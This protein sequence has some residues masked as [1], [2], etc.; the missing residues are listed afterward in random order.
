MLSTGVAL[1]VAATT[2]GTASSATR[3]VGSS[4]AL[5][6]GTLRVVQSAGAFDTLDPQLAYVYNDWQVLH[7]T[8]LLLVDRPD[9]AGQAGGQLQPEGAKSFP[10]ISNKGRT[11]TFHLREGLRFSDGSPVT[12]ASYRRAWERILSP[13]MFAQYGVFDQLNAMVVGAQKFTDD[14]AAHIS[15]IDA[16][17]LTLTFHLTKPNATFIST[18]A[19]PWLGAVKPSMPYTKK[20]T[21]ILEYPSA[22]PYYIAADRPG[23]LVVLKRNRYYHGARPAN[24]DEIVIRSYPSSNGEAALLQIEQNQVDYDMA[25]VPAADVATV[26]QKYGYP[27]NR[28][29]QFHVGTESCVTWEALNY[30]R[31]PTNDPRVRKALNYALGRT[32]ITNLWGPYA[33]TPTDQIL[34][35]GMPGYEKFTLYGNDPNVAKAEQVGG[36]SPK[37]APPLTIGYYAASALST[38]EAELEQSE[39]HQIGLTVNL[40]PIPQYGPFETPFDQYN[41]VQSGYC[42]DYFDGFDLIHLF[43]TKKQPGALSPYAFHDASFARQAA[44]AASLTGRARVRAYAALDRLLMTKYAPVVPLYVR[45][46]RYL[47]SKR[48]HNIVFSHYLG[49]PILNAM[50]VR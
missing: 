21:G 19:I 50:S 36:S 8:Q 37:N 27:E 41:I 35:P 24:P 14:K 11:V 12:A 3:K 15:G 18:L 28:Q 7:S 1:L 39:L 34:V 6:G 26:A 45:N 42:A 5:R 22:G 43:A 23:S 4:E 40:S 2:V 48:V 44:H 31:P 46:F 29:S 16:H 17:G 30:D 47:T 32:Q 49:G 9:K 10:T 25:G 33:G 13:R 20:A 38:N